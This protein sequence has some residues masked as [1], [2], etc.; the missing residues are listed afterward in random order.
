MPISLLPLIAISCNNQKQDD[1]K[2]QKIDISKLNLE[3]NPSNQIKKEEILKTLI[4]KTA[5]KELEFEKDLDIKIKKAEIE[6]QGLIEITTTKKS[7][8]FNWSNK[9]HY[10]KT[11]ER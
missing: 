1:N 4:S 5:I 3:I 7:K 6:K 11:S 2:K 9:Y 8:L 10:S